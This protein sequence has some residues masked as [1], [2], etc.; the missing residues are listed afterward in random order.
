MKLRIL[1]PGKTKN[2]ELRGLEEYYLGRIRQLEPCQLVEIKTSRGISEKFEDRIK[3]IEAQG[4]EKHFQSDYIVCL[5]D[6]GKEMSSVEFARFLEDKTAHSPKGIAFVMG[7]FL[8]LAQRILDKAD[9]LLSLS[10]MT[11]S[12]EL[13]RI[14]LLEQIYRSLTLL[15]GRKYPK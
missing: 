3:E 2:R 14:I 8:G 6:Q 9:L 4:L 13:S 7:G 11:F 10:K 1:W 15:K 5:S 12:H